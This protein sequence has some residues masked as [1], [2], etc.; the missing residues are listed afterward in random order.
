MINAIEKKQSRIMKQG[1]LW[2]L[3]RVFRVHLTEV[4]T[5]G[6]RFEGGTASHPDI[7]KEDT[8]TASARPTGE[9]TCVVS[10]N[11]GKS[12]PGE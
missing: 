3:S 11:T 2:V 5:F 7:V 9:S 4:V 8:G 10:T 6:R 12:K 1:K